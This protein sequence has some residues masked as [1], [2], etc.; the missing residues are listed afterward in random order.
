MCNKASSEGKD[1]QATS[2]EL[3]EETNAHYVSP[4]GESLEEVY[5]YQLKEGKSQSPTVAL[6]INGIPISLHLDTQADVTVVTKKH[7]GKLQ[8]K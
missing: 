1:K 6:T 5:L 7:Y 4:E 2:V 8:A 3:N